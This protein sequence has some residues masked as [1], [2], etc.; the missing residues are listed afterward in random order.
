MTEADFNTRITAPSEWTSEIILPEDQ[1]TQYAFEY[2]NK[3]PLPRDGLPRITLEGI[4]IL[5]EG[6]RGDFHRWRWGIG[7][8]PLE[9][10]LEHI[11]NLTIHCMKDEPHFMASFWFGEFPQVNYRV[12]TPWVPFDTLDR[13][14][15]QYA[16]KDPET[17]HLAASQDWWMHISVQVGDNFLWTPKERNRWTPTHE[18]DD[19]EDPEDDQEDDEPV[20][21]GI[22]PKNATLDAWMGSE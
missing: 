13:R 11:R 8:H 16:D 3:C 12:M 22:R 17:I 20:C 7:N 2:E 6:L 18:Y 4:E 14:I 15:T 1:G 9:M 10:P 19:E 21:P 5:S